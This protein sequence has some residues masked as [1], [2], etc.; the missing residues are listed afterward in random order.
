MHWVPWSLSSARKE[1][2][3]GAKE[4]VEAAR[5]LLSQSV[6]TLEGVQDG[7]R[8]APIGYK[9]QVF[10]LFGF[11][12]PSVFH[13]WSHPA[14]TPQAGNGLASA[15]AGFFARLLLVHVT[16][17]ARANTWIAWRLPAELTA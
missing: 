4:Q 2:S 6:T 13:S 7:N 16:L 14:N 5:S 15:R 3:R 11:L 1:F 12:V 10:T 17:S 9:L 8:S